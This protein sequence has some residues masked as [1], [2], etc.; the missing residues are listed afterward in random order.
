[1]DLP[2]HPKLANLDKNFGNYSRI[3]VACGLAVDSFS[4]GLIRPASEVDDAK[5]SMTTGGR[6]RVREQPDRDELYP[7]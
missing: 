3:S 4:L 2:P 6:L 7:K 5:P 1:M